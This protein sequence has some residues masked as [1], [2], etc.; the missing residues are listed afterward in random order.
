VISYWR[1]HRRR[2]WCLHL[3]DR[4]LDHIE[5]SA[6]APNVAEPVQDPVARQL[7]RDLDAQG[8]ATVLATSSRLRVSLPLSDLVTF[9]GSGPE[10]RLRLLDAGL[11]ARHYALFLVG[12]SIYG[13]DLH[14]AQRDPET[15]CGE[16]WTPKTVVHCGGA[17]LRPRFM[18]RGT[19]AG[20]HELSLELRGQVAGHSFVT[21]LRTLITLIG[22]GK[23]CTVRLC[24][25]GVAPVQA[26]LVRLPHS[27]VLIDLAD[28]TWTR[29]HDEP[30]RWSLLDPTDE[31]E[32]GRTVF[33]VTAVWDDFTP[34]AEPVA[35]AR[36]NTQDSARM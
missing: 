12:G 17:Q 5:T 8:C 20:A 31:F 18:G 19:L 26:A 21:P 36:A 4:A 35:L 33:Q 14:R 15:S 28:N 13:I 29:R 1:E 23:W 7:T 32:I 30:V 34:A 22:S 6:P 9:V 24:D 2:R 11:D 3:R 25:P 10:C 16:W 27:L